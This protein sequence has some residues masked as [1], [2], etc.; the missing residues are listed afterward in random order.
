MQKERPP[1][2][3]SQPPLRE[4]SPLKP[5]MFIG[6]HPPPGP[7][8]AKAFVASVEPPM[9]GAVP[10]PSPS[11]GSPFPGGSAPEASLL[12]QG[13][14]PLASGA[15][16]PGQ[17]SVRLVMR[18]YAPNSSPASVSMGASPM[19]RE[20]LS[21]ANKAYAR[22]DVLVATF[23]YAPPAQT[24]AQGVLGFARGDVFH[25]LLDS[26]AVGGGASW[27]YAESENGHVRGYV[28][29][30]FVQH[31]AVHQASAPNS[32]AVLL[33]VAPR[34][35]PR[36][37]E[38]IRQDSARI[39][40]QEQLEAKLEG[41]LEQAKTINT[42]MAKELIA[43]QAKETE[44]RELALAA[45]KAT[46][47]LHEARVAQTL[48]DRE[49]RV[50]A[51][52]L[53]LERAQRE[54][55]VKQRL[56]DIEREALDKADEERRATEREVEEL[57][58]QAL[59]SKLSEDSVQTDWMEH[60]NVL[61]SA[62]SVRARGFQWHG[63]ASETRSKDHRAQPWQMAW[64]MERERAKATAN[65]RPR[66]RRQAHRSPA[67]DLASTR[68]RRVRQAHRSPAP[69]TPSYGRGRGGRAAPRSGAPVVPAG[70]PTGASVGQSPLAAALHQERARASNPT[71]RAL[72]RASTL[73]R[74]NRR[75]GPRTDPTLAAAFALQSVGGKAPAS[76]MPAQV[77][78]PAAAPSSA[79]SV[80]KRSVVRISPPPAGFRP[81]PQRVLE[82][83]NNAPPPGF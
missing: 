65:T 82:D 83:P 28:P 43:L 4:A 17:P 47:E 78:A 22:G 79:R 16:A 38:R 41:E 19:R 37:P 44:E 24:Q 80:T 56:L 75:G 15:A 51:H 69:A 40:A 67:P 49:E 52:Q 48:A 71:Q 81:R 60:V 25:V 36:D 35:I 30:K 58:R 61:P 14:G 18:Q 23:D 5:S 3:A 26:E 68:S 55:A 50:G 27:V 63:S 34:L 20:L 54:V 10:T 13:R 31:T 77:S 64:Q 11:V 46:F 21:E 53:E 57:Q 73:Q 6:A 33:G 42:M 76:D 66:G 74:A 9:R 32:P 45:Q 39:E 7:P 29:P 70:P 59:E 1:P 12:S 62:R 72:P 2:P 8:P